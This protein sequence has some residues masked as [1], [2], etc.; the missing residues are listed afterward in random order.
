MAIT[1]T[2]ANQKWFNEYKNGVGFASNPTD[3]ALNLSGSVAAFVVELV[4][5][6]KPQI[7]K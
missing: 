1:V 3:F 4:I 5:E 2:V 7:G 6:I